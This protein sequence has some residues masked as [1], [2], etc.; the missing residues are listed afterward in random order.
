MKILNARFI[1]RSLLLGLIKI[2]YKLLPSTYSVK[3]AIRSQDKRIYNDD[4]SSEAKLLGVKKNYENVDHWYSTHSLSQS[5]QRANI[6][7]IFLAALYP[8][9]T[10]KLLDI[11]GG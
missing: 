1:V 7:P 6:L 8:P 11:G 10:Y 2:T 4:E 3:P 5:I 9:R